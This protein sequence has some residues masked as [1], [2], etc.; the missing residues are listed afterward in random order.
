MSDAGSG[1]EFVRFSKKHLQILCRRAIV[2]T[3]IQKDDDEDSTR[4]GTSYQRAGAGGSPVMSGAVED[5]L[6]VAVPNRLAAQ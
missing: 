1:T 5:H 3:I 6:P 2:I 4:I